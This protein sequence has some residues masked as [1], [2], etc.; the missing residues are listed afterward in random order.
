[1]Y[2][3][4]VGDLC[5]GSRTQRCFIVVRVEQDHVVCLYGDDFEINDMKY[6]SIHIFEKKV[7]NS[8]KIT[9]VQRL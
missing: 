8:K 9:R 4:R 6:H 1:M 5:V 3:M 2:K 7:F